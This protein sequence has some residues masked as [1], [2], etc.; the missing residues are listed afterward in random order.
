MRLD[1]EKTRSA[2]SFKS[3]AEARA[4][5]YKADWSHYTPKA[6]NQPGVIVIKDLDL[7]ILLPYI[8]WFPFFCTWQVRGKYPNRNYPKIFNDPEAGPQAKEL[9]DNAQAMIKDVIDNKRLTAN[10]VV[11]IFPCKS[12]ETDSVIMEE[13]TVFHM[14]R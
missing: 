1:Y 12:N 9:W 2:R 13:G 7:N 10:G 11:G 6:P 14:L 8:D 5:Q 3:I 4:K